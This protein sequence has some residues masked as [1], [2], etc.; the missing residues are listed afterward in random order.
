MVISIN[1]TALV[2]HVNPAVL[3]DVSSQKTTDDNLRK[4]VSVEDTIGALPNL[5]SNAKEA[6]RLFAEAIRNERNLNQLQVK[7]EAQTHI[8]DG[9]KNGFLIAACHFMATA[10]DPKFV[11]AGAPVTFAMERLSQIYEELGTIAHKR[12]KMLREG[13]L[14][15]TQDVNGEVEQK[16]QQEE[17]EL[18]AC[19]KEITKEYAQPLLSIRA[20]LEDSFKKLHELTVKVLALRQHLYAEKAEKLSDIKVEEEMLPELMQRYIAGLTD[21]QHD[22]DV[23]LNVLNDPMMTAFIPPKTDTVSTVTEH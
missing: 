21:T 3:Q 20:G 13:S 22:I 6:M 19:L 17:A 10:K 15:D 14:H 4:P 18:N 23:Y 16:L 11:E 9:K 8:Y 12:S 1:N 7:L 5:S 2:N